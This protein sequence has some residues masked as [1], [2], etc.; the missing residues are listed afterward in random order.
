MLIE[1][2]QVIGLVFA[3]QVKHLLADYFLQTKAMIEGRR[4]YG[5]RGGIAHVAIHGA[6]SLIV[7]ALFGGLSGIV[8]LIVLVEMIV[9][10]HIDW[11]KDNIVLRLGITPD[12]RSYWIAAGT[13]QA[14]HQATY[15]VMAMTWLAFVYANP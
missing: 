8:V 14:L 9:H 11:S 5:H 1:T 4:S 12:D 3:L 13:D 2:W 7:F 10:Y 6:G 15:L